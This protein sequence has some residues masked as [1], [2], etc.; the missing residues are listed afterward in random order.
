MDGWV[1]GW[2][3]D[4]AT[5]H[6]RPK[7]A[8]H[9]GRGRSLTVV[10]AIDEISGIYEGVIYIKEGEEEGV[11]QFVV[12]SKG[13][14]AT[15]FLLYSTHTWWHDTTL[16]HLSLSHFL[17]LFHAFLTPFL[18]FN[19]FFRSSHAPSLTTPLSH[20]QNIFVLKFHIRPL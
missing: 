5:S 15:T 11:F 16:T 3:S 8:A 14:A 2:L 19:P 13:Y 1:V 9:G 20:G 18:F 10:Q 4:S 6:R 7:R 17:L 12:S